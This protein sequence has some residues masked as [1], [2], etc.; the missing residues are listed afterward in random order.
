MRHRVAGEIADDHDTARVARLPFR[1][2]AVGELRR[3]TAVAE[4]AGV[5]LEQ[6]L[7][8]DLLGWLA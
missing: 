1:D 7:H 6:R 4:Q 5:D 2:E 8:V 3:L